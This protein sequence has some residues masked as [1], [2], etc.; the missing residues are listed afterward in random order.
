MSLFDSRGFSAA[1]FFRHSL[2]KSMKAFAGLG[3]R[4]DRFARVRCCSGKILSASRLPRDS[5]GSPGMRFSTA[6]SLSSSSSSSSSSLSSSLPSRFSSIEERTE[7]V[8]S[9][10]RLT[11]SIFLFTE[12]LTAAGGSVSAADTITVTF[13]PFTSS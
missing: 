10:Y 5:F 2:A 13:P 9:S 8:A 11:S 1:S 6:F 3:G 12:C 7:K 4:G